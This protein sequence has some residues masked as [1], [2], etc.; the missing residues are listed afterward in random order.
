MEV[1]FTTVKRSP[2]RLWLRHYDEE[3]TWY[4]DFTADELAFARKAGLRRWTYFLTYILHDKDGELVS[5]SISYK[6]VLSS[7]ASNP[8][9]I[10]C[11][12]ADYIELM[13]KVKA[14]LYSM[15][16]YMMHHTEEVPP[17]PLEKPNNLTFKI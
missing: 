10:P 7:S 8:V 12:G 15:K 17:P 2:L 16:H 14:G 3:L 11:K 5:R 6:K 13:S 4:V 9:R 1:H